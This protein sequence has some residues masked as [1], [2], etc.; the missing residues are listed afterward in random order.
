MRRSA[1][2][3]RLCSTMRYGRRRFF[4]ICIELIGSMVCLNR[5][6]LMLLLSN[7]MKRNRYSVDGVDGLECQVRQRRNPPTLTFVA[8]DEIVDF[9]G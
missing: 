4:Y 5:Q 7:W 3:P 1:T 6:R 9:L 2:V 8:T